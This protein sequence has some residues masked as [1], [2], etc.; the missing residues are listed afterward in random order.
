MPTNPNSEPSE[1][2]E[3]N[4]KHR[5]TGAAVLLFLGAAVL[6]W[7]L[8]PP[9]QA[10]KVAPSTTMVRPSELP[11]DIQEA[12]L[13]IDNGFDVEETVYI[14]KITP[15]DAN[16]R[17]SLQ[18]KTE[19]ESPVLVDVAI[20]DSV[21][22]QKRQADDKKKADRAAIAKSAL[23][24]DTKLKEE[25]RLLA[26]DAAR[27]QENE[28]QKSDATESALQAKLAKEKALAANKVDVGWI[29]Q[30]GLFTEKN[31]AVA[32]ISELKNKGFSA[33]SN[34]VD[35]NRGKNTGTRVWLGPFARKASAANEVKRLKA[36]AAKDG[37]I[38][39]YP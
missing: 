21:A 24:R 35:T 26:E 7:L 39:V 1:N 18:E 13:L 17:P 22:S 2:T 9:S 31:R 28:K 30:V 27:K 8:G 11:A 3:F 12:D 25:K 4:L 20:T 16:K 33:S 29:V 34:V 10:S 32:F 36:K 6:P 37:F 19:K 38:R 23:D 15:M 5:I 14:S